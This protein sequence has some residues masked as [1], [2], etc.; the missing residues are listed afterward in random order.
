MGS[1]DVHT[2]AGLKWLPLMKQQGILSEGLFGGFRHLKERAAQ[3]LPLACLTNEVSHPVKWLSLPSKRLNNLEL[4]LRSAV[5]ANLSSVHGVSIPVSFIQS[6]LIS[7]WPASPHLCKKLWQSGRL[8]SNKG[9]VLR[10]TKT[11]EAIIM[12][13]FTTRQLAQRQ[14][15]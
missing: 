5:I 11:K 3:R 14:A 8:C 1:I 13:K 6:R 9:V 4:A 15:C 10:V 12:Y 7:T 2:F